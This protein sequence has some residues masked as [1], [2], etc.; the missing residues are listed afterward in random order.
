MNAPEEDLV[1][2]DIK[3]LVDREDVLKRHKNFEDSGSI[4]R[5]TGEKYWD[6][7]LKTGVIL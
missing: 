6:K 3:N 1:E 4:L 5:C 7:F 2:A